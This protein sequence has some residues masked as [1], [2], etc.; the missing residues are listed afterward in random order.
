MAGAQ[1]QVVEAEDQDPVRV[2]GVGMRA[3]QWAIVDR[4]AAEMGG[5][6][7]WALRHIVEEYQ[8][9]K[10]EGLCKRM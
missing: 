4:E 6:R 10:A 9:L 8:R 5:S 1:E 3:R 7:S 2:L